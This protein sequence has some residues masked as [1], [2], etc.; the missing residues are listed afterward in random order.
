MSSSC[1]GGS[2]SPEAKIGTKAAP[3]PTNGASK[4]TATQ[5][6]KSECCS[7]KPDKSEKQGCGC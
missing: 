7:D 3:M 2:S 1:C 5:P 6:Y 4:P